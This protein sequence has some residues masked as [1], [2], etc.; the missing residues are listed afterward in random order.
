MD[1]NEHNHTALRLVELNDSGFEI[2]DNQPDIITWTIVDTNDNE[3]GEVTDLIFDKETSKVRYIVSLIDLAEEEGTRF[4]LIP[5]GIVDLNETEEEV[6]IP[7]KYSGA[8]ATLP[9]YRCGT[10]IS[11]AEELAVRY[12]FLGT[13]GL[14]NTNDDSY[15]AHPEDFYAHE[16]F[17]DE[18]FKKR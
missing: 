10:V 15:Q 12:A 5:I 8:L 3:L 14:M 6:V 13:E 16:H 18:K 9:T 4:V 11:P 1:I 17:N 7:K 2:R